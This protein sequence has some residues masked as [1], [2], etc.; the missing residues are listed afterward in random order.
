MSLFFSAIVPP[1]CQ[2]TISK[3][4]VVNKPLRPQKD[5]YNVNDNGI[6]YRCNL[7][8]NSGLKMV[9]SRK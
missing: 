5:K 4:C 8:R 6:S 3:T 1:R 9:V 7:K 2:I